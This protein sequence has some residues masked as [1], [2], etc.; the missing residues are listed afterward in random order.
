MNTFDV[1]EEAKEVARKLTETINDKA[2][3]VRDA[4]SSTRYNL[5]DYIQN[6]PWS[7]IAFAGAFGLLLGIVVARR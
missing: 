6:N 1:P 4:A 3:Y 5:E 2:N 7:A